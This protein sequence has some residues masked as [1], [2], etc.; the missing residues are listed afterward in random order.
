[1][2]LSH[3]S[4][5]EKSNYPFGYL[6]VDRAARTSVSGGVGPF[7]SEVAVG[8]QAKACA[9]PCLSRTESDGLALRT[10][11]IQRRIPRASA[12][13]LFTLKRHSCPSP[14]SPSW[15]HKLHAV[16][17]PRGNRAP[18]TCPQRRVCRTE[19]CEN[20]FSSNTAAIAAKKRESPCHGVWKL[21]RFYKQAD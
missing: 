1:M 16:M 14:C 7:G 2:S 19:I 12:S 8:F 15:S 4:S 6:D 20:W 3:A 18:Q 5:R 10:R 17:L 11:K 21:L 13:L 9:T